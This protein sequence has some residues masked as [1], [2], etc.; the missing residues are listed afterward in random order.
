MPP[1]SQPRG[2]GFGVRGVDRRIFIECTYTHFSGGSTGIQRVVRSV[3]GRCGNV[4]EDLGARCIP[5]IFEGGKFWGIRKVSRK[6]LRSAVLDQAA[7]I[8][9]FLRRVYALLAGLLHGALPR[10]PAITRFLFPPNGHRGLKTI[11]K[12]VGK[13]LLS[14]LA[15]QYRKRRIA[16]EDGDVL[17]LLDASWQLDLWDALA[18]ARKAGTRVV[19][20]IY[21]LIP[22]THPQFCVEEHIRAFEGWLRNVC[23]HADSFIA[24]SDTVARELA[25]R[26]QS[27]SSFR[28]AITR[29]VDH[30]YLG[31]DFNTCPRAGPSPAVGLRPAGG[32]VRKDLLDVFAPTTGAGAYLTVGTLEPRKNHAYLLDAFERVWEKRP[33]VRLCIAGA[34]GWLS[35][36]VR[37]R[38]RGHPLYGK[39]L[40]MFHDL[41]D[42]ELS[43]CYSRAKALLFPSLAEGFGLPIVEALDHGAVVFANDIAAF[44]EIGEEYCAFFDG[45]SP[46]SLARIVVD[47]ETTGRLPVRRSPKEFRWTDWTESCRSLLGKALETRPARRP[48]KSGPR[49]TPPASGGADDTSCR[50]GPMCPPS[51]VG[52]EGPH[53]GGPPQ[54]NDLHL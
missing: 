6:P 19:A 28:H 49:D 2:R 20:V 46:E 16:W 34:K 29:T 32:R 14:P 9:V 43:Y 12:S 53:I 47:Y 25:R 11:L 5:V 45:T 10:H 40:F 51:S 15:W 37:E 22:L 36:A 38:I 13:V 54:E 50:G 42:A 30:F 17:I 26:L 31:C 48:D 21:D 3:C 1:A 23:E 8:R 33:E 7:P 52:K 18:E 35:E 44:R 39:R 27:D 4:G 41:S 24:I